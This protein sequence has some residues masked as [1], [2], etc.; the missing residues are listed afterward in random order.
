MSAII[1]NLPRGFYEECEGKMSLNKEH[2]HRSP[3][4]LYA[5][6]NIQRYYSTRKYYYF[7]KTNVRERKNKHYDPKKSKP[8]RRLG[9]IITVHENMECKHNIT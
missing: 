9:R 1:V 4:K 8:T 7:T 2:L 3:I 6:L 5:Y